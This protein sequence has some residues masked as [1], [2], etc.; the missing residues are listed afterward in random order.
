MHTGNNHRSA[1]SQIWKHEVGDPE[2]NPILVCLRE[3]KANYEEVKD[4]KDHHIVF[5]TS[6]L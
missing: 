4:I 2:Q 1:S 3:K 5:K 6:K